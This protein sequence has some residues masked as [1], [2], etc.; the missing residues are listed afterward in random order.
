VPDSPVSARSCSSATDGRWREHLLHGLR[1]AEHLGYA[2]ATPSRWSRALSLRGRAPHEARPLV[3]VERLGRYSNA[4]PGRPPPRS[5]D[6]SARSSR[7]PQAR[8]PGADVLEHLEPLRPGM[9]MSVTST[10]AR[11][12][13]SAASAASACRT[14]GSRVPPVSARS[15]TQRIDASSSTT[16]H[17]CLAEF[18]LSNGKRMVKTCG[19]PA[20]EFDQPVVATDEVLGDREAEPCRPGGGDQRV[21]DRVLEV[22]GHSRAVVLDLDAG[23]HAVARLPMLA[24]VS[25]RVRSTMRPRSPTAWMALRPRFSSAW[26]IWLRSSRSAQLGS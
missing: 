23:D 17:Q 18:M 15:S 25:A 14:N 24:L 2:A 1:M 10:S 3:D 9:R 11:P 22:R 13:R 8:A 21:E 12:W 20:V 4:P 16:R 7:S 26:M 5:R 6:R 19:R